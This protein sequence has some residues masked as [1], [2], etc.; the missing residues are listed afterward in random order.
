MFYRKYGY[1]IIMLISKLVCK[2]L[3]L[4]LPI[5]T[6]IKWIETSDGDVVRKLFKKLAVQKTTAKKN[7]H[8]L[9]C[10]R[11]LGVNK[12]FKANIYW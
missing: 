6:F 2:V 10:V 5:E 9:G 11:Y 1:R 7:W 3:F 4:S 8:C 12:F